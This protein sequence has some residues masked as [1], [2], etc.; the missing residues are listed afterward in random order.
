MEVWF[1]MIKDV[2]FPA[3]VTFFLLHRIEGKLD[4][5]IQSVRLL[6]INQETDR[7]EERLQKQA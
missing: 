5:L 4:E 3:V 1:S 6:P 7:T 2:G